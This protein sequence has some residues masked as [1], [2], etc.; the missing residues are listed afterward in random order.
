MGA[1]LAAKGIRLELPEPVSA[2]EFFDQDTRVIVQLVN[3]ET[4]ECI[5]S[6]FSTFQRNTAEAFKASSD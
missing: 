6:E 1:L 3:D 5:T 4:A 2:N